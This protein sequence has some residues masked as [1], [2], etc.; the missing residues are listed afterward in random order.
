MYPKTTP[1][2]RPATGSIK[3]E[4]I[5]SN[6]R[7]LKRHATREDERICSPVKRQRVVNDMDVKHLTKSRP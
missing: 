6:A 3:L 7:A 5:G 4:R 2:N 1:K